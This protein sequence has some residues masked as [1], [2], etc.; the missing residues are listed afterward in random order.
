MATPLVPQEIFLLER[1]TSWQ[2]FDGMRTAWSAM[3]DHAEKA[4]AVFERHLPANYR[5]RPL[6]EQPDI[7]W[8]ERVLVNFRD[9]RDYLDSGFIRLTHG[10]FTALSGANGVMNDF[11]GFSRDYSAD[12]MDEPSVAA[13]MP[14]AADEFW[15]L[16][17]CATEPAFNI[18][19]TFHA[20][21]NT[22]SL[23]HRYSEEDRGPLNPPAEWPLYRPNRK[24]RATTGQP[25]QRTGIYLPDADDSAPAFMVEGRKAP[26]AS[27]GFDPVRMQNVSEAATSWTLVERVADTGG[28]IPGAADEPIAGL[29]LR[30]EGGQPCPREGWW[31]TPAKAN[32]RRHFTQGE[33][34]PRFT[35]DYGATIWQ[36]DDRQGA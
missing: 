17:G 28:G 24:F 8:G 22:G 5:K 36:W 15:R 1:Y 10:D 23:G 32:S 16:L 6:P 25:V 34:M 11:I 13:V 9:T 7:V 19:A 33:V 31:F 26:L 27:I 30:C 35:T 14:G 12:W 20:H 2:Y 4:L 21:W 18:K 29:R 3:V